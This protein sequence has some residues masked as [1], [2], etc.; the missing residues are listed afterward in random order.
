MPLYAKIMGL[1][2]AIECASEK[3]WDELWIECDSSLQV[4]SS[5]SL[6]I[7]MIFLVIDLASRFLEFVKLLEDPLFFYIILEV[8]KKKV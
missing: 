4:I 7:E 8:Y 3:Y 6:A 5:H 2:L 1:I